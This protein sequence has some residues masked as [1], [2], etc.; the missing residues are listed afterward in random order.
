[1]LEGMLV[2]DVFGGLLVF[3]RV[4]SAIV[5]LPGFS[6]GYVPMRVRLLI[7][8]AISAVVLTSVAGTLPPVPDRPDALLL[9]LLSEILIG[10][11]VGSIPRVLFSALQVAGTFI[12]FLSAFAN[13]LT[14]DP[15]ADQQSST[16]AGFLTTLGLVLVFVTDLHHLMLHSLVESY[17][18]FLPG[19]PV[20]TGDMAQVI[21]RTA[22]DAFT[23]GIQLAAPFVV[24]ALVY[25][26]GLGLLSKLMPQLQV[27][28]IGQSAQ[29]GLQ[30]WVM[31]LVLSGIMMV[32]FNR[33]AEALGDMMG[34]WARPV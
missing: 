24:V 12:A 13:A 27:F 8:L 7:A 23:L 30:L 29:V 26:V 14:Q 32:F 11:F 18:V 17:A 33:Y 28:F 21:A 15:I 4:G 10:L 16:I 1:M 6:A 20:P 31:M 9:L 2:T 19:N 3:A 25:N 34:G 22:A 5:V